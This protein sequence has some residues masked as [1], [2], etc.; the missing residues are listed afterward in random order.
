MIKG[1][2][3]CMTRAFMLT[4]IYEGKMSSYE[5]SS[6]IY[7]H[8]EYPKSFFCCCYFLSLLLRKHCTGKNM[9]LFLHMTRYGHHSEAI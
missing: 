9:F 5:P 8:F 1:S 2:V 4:V 3:L 6:Q 7:N